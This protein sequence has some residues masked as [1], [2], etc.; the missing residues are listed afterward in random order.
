[1]GLNSSKINLGQIEEATFPTLRNAHPWIKLLENV[2]QALL[3]NVS[4]LHFLSN[5]HVPSR[6]Y[7]LFVHGLSYFSKLWVDIVPNLETKKDA[8][9]E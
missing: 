5:L 2:T 4:G 3:N 1:M 7:M 8:E 9:I 6:C